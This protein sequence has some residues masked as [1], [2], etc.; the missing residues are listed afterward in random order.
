MSMCL[1]CMQDKE[2]KSTCPFC[3]YDGSEKE[4]Q[5]MYLAPKTVL[6]ERYLIG[7]V[8]SSNGGGPNYAAYDLI[9]KK[10]VMV[11]E[12]MPD[13]L[14]DR[15]NKI[16]NKIKVIGGCEMQYKTFMIDF[17]ELNKNLMRF[18][19]LSHIASI[20]DVFEENNTVYAVSEY[21]DGESLTLFLNDNNGAVSWTVAKQMLAPLLS[22]LREV[23]TAGII[24]RGIS[25]ETLVV[26]KEGYLKLTAFSISPVRTA[27]SELSAEI[28]HG[29]APLEQYSPSIWHG[30]WT[31]VYAICAV[32]YK[33]LTGFAPVEAQL[34]A[35]NDT[36]SSPTSISQKVPKNISSVIMGG[37]KLA[38]EKRIQNI[39]ELSEMLY[40]SPSAVSQVQERPENSK[41]FKNKK[42]KKPIST[43]IVVAIV[44]GVTM[45][46]L[47]GAVVIIF[48][49]FGLAPAT[50][51]APVVSASSTVTSTAP[52]YMRRYN[53]SKTQT[54][55]MNVEE[56]KS[57]LQNDPMWQYF[58]VKIEY[59]FD[60][61]V[62]YGT[63]VSTVP[64][65]SVEGGVD[66]SVDIRSGA[67]KTP[68][69]V[70]ISTGPKNITLPLNS[71][72]GRPFL[73]VS[74]D[75]SFY[76]CTF[77]EVSRAFSEVIPEDC[78]ISADPPEGS[79]I[80]RGDNPNNPSK[81]NINLVVSKGKKMGQIPVNDNND[82]AQTY[83]SIL[84]KA[85]FSVRLSMVDE[86][87]A[88]YTN[89]IRIFIE[90]PDGM[91]FPYDVINKE[92]D[93]VVIVYSS[94]S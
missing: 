88:E 2:N 82:D 52:S 7:L 50:P 5:Y 74:N 48:R 39:D 13:A 85:N 34:R 60:D 57:S 15:D 1:N 70:V 42:E 71:L 37:L 53:I 8:R 17:M 38:P 67:E 24:H 49:P 12:Y 94:E 75:L 86:P 84:E 51:S 58:D 31:D 78:I 81:P 55:N 59:A 77:K 80:A 22:A 20:Y 16:D 40:A 18:N 66:M 36:L 9:D 47:I 92:T 89:I 10:R 65:A 61:K 64:D 93:T 32:I 45:V 62:P 26:T 83:K 23:H 30:T 28:F 91:K 25:P 11:S 21:I 69:K 76:Y 72:V 6:K 27:R 56:F 44:F 87:P 90:S 54:L 19:E 33:M 63:M 79:V 3:G 4:T 43:G 14:C 68:F 73:Q 46:L 35:T 29:Y 41:T